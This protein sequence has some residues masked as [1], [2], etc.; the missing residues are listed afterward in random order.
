MRRPWTLMILN[1]L[2]KTETTYSIERHLQIERI[3]TIL[4][5]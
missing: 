5:E 4:A 1:H 3:A 2:E